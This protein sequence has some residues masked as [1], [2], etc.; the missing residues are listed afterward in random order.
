MIHWKFSPIAMIMN[1]H[2]NLEVQQ[3]E[4]INGKSEV[5]IIKSASAK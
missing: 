2:I 1:L 4:Y 5:N 3:N